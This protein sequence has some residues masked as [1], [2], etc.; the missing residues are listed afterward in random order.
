MKGRVLIIDTDQEHANSVR[1][2]LQEFGYETATEFGDLS[3]L[4]ALETFQPLVVIT[5][6]LK[7]GPH[8]FALL[9]ELRERQPQTPVILIA[10]DNSADTA[11]HAIQEEGAYYYFE[12]PVNFDRFHIGLH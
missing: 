3:G 10:D 6:A 4:E 7:P 5:D 2:R 1:E 12:K 11:V 9:R 8:Q